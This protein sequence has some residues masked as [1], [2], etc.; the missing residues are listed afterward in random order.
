MA[1][2]IKIIGNIINTTTVSR[3]SS[4]DAALI[5]SRNLQ[6]NF[7]GEGDYIEYFVYDIGGNL[8]NINYSYLDYKLP[9]NQGLTPGVDTLPNTNGSIQTTDVG[10]QSTLATPTSSLY[11]II[12]IDPVADLQNLGYSSGEFQVRYNFFQNKISNYFNQDLFVKEISPNRTEVRLASTTLTNEQI[13]SGSLD[14]IDKLNNSDYYVDYI[15]NFG[16]NEQYIAVNVA[17]D[18]NPN[19]FEILFK[20]YQPLPLSVQEKQTL[21]V[22]EEIVNPYV[23]D[24]NLDKLIT[25]PPPPTLRG[26]N[27]N[28]PVENQGTISTSYSNYSNLISSIQSLQSSSYSKIQNLMSTQSIDINVDYTDFNNFVFFGSAYQRVVN[29]YNKVKQIEDYNNFI[30]TY[31]PYVATTASLQTT[32][33]QYSASIVNV[34]T[35]FDGYEYY[36]YFESSSYAWPK[37]NSNKPFILL[38]TGSVQTW[39]NNLTASAKTYDLNNYDNLEFAVP[40]FI[41]D[42]ENNQPFLLFLNM[43]GQYFDNIWIYLKS[44]TDINLANNNLDYGISKDLVYQQLQSL[45]VKLYNSQAGDSVANYLIGANTG[46]SIWDND[47]TITGSY[48]NNIPRKDLVAELYKRIYHNLPLLLKTKGTVA[49]LNYLMTIFGIPNQTYYVIT[50][51]SITQSYYT[52]TGSNFT[53][54]ILNVKEFGGSLKSELIKGYNN[55]KVRI[56]S[57]TITGSVLSSELSLQTYPTTSATF[58]DDDLHYV[59]ISFSPQTQIDTYISGAIASNNST[60]SLDD[61]IGDPR[62]QYSASYPDLDNQRKLYF[63]TGTPGYPGFTGSLLDYNGFIRLIE[64]FDNSLFKMLNDFVPERTSLSTGVTINSPVLERN[65]TVYSVPNVTNQQIYEANYQTSSITAQYGP[66][67]EDLQGDKKPFFTGELSGSVV[68]VNQYF[69]D[70]YNQYLGDWNVWN[71]QHTISESIDLNKFLHSDWNV[72]L[73]NVSSSVKSQFRNNIEYTGN[74]LPTTSLTYPA[75]LQDS[76]LTLR[77][78]NT[79]RYE[80]SKLTSLT[81]NIYTSGSYTGSNG[82]SIQNG[83]KSYGKTAV[84]DRQS[85]KIGWV[86]NIPSQSLNFFDKTQIQLKY[87]VDSNLNITDL[88]L[89]NNN[90][91]EIQNTFKSGD[92]VVLSLSDTTKPSFQKPL[93]GTKTIFRGGYSYDPILYREQKE[94]LYI[95]LNNT[96][97]TTNYLG[98]KATATDFYSYQNYGAAIGNMAGGPYPI[99]NPPADLGNPRFNNNPLS[100]LSGFGYIFL[101]NYGGRTQA[102]QGSLLTTPMVNEV[103]DPTG[104]SNL[105]STLA[106][107]PQTSFPD[108]SWTGPIAQGYYDHQSGDRRVYVFD[109]SNSNSSTYISFNNSNLNNGFVNGYTLDNFTDRNQYLFKAQTP[110][111]YTISGNIPFFMRLSYVKWFRFR[112]GIFATSNVPDPFHLFGAKFK[113]VAVV[114]KSNNPTSPNSWIY[115]ASTRIQNAYVPGGGFTYNANNNEFKIN[116]GLGGGAWDSDSTDG[117][118]NAGLSSSNNY[119]Y[120]IAFNLKF[121]N[122][123]I[124]SSTPDEINV[125]LAAGEV[126]RLRLYFYDVDAFFTWGRDASFDIGKP[127]TRT[128]LTIPP[129]PSVTGFTSAEIDYLNDA[130]FAIE[131]RSIPIVNYSNIV[132]YNNDNV[133]TGTGN[134]EILFTPTISSYIVSG[135]IFTPSSLIGTNNYYSPIVDNLTIQSQ[136]LIRI[137][138]I[139]DPTPSYYTVKNVEEY[140]ALENGSSFTG[141]VAFASS[142]DFNVSTIPTQY[143]SLGRRSVIWFPNNIV[144]NNGS[145]QNNALSDY[146]NLIYNSTDING[147]KK[148][149]IGNMQNRNGISPSTVFTIKDIITCRVVFFDSSLSKLYPMTF[150]IL[151]DDLTV[152]T[153]QRAFNTDYND[154]VISSNTIAPSLS[155]PYTNTNPTPTFFPQI[156]SELYIKAT[157]DKDVSGTA[158]LPLSQISQNFAILRPKPDE[159]SII[160]EYSKQLGD[161]SQT[162]L[163]PQDANDEIKNNIGKIFQSLNVDLSNQNITQ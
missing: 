107:Q 26:P 114:E 99:S 78:Y 89:K 84:I 122:D 74:F 148:I 79:S 28:I 160:I 69:E 81:Y 110:G 12:E 123:N 161:V 136:D 126:L 39:Y 17:L 152:P 92:N 112:R 62:Q 113:I 25:P 9:P 94:P 4:Q 19:G 3:Y 52:P 97:S 40:N 88:T 142:Y 29:F 43:V 147:A 91:F 37:I 143:R 6:D 44:I 162:I 137:G 53:S 47:F 13:K 105:Y 8:L 76:Y 144:G 60:W 96:I 151:S 71:L 124:S 80:G 11:P 145:S 22:T 111:T 95:R 128:S 146:F 125:T 101:K 100:S 51:G 36:L 104:F 50:S 140:Y 139:N 63:Q 159:T 138:S 27:F 16:N 34:I 116:S 158:L 93:D 35:Q 118:E 38:S 54:S 141:N 59:D 154:W 24:I 117:G 64:Y 87:L 82:I 33:N 127:N 132:E 56:V 156:T 163:I 85:Y 57:N 157:L 149:T 30:T 83:D 115:V 58:R 7:G 49:G 67:Y 45:G 130:V 31:A 102:S 70:N 20:L 129:F 42:D 14:L 10:V 46:S 103:L 121:K 48:L 90:L 86:K 55:N 75:E 15:L 77:S 108:I 109:L 133:F 65:K 131:E 5:S 41:R 18:E 32:I 72:L 98:Y 155:T 23:F 106:N 1:N 134:N 135:S 68:D 119:L 66:L 21:W 153:N 61:F 73:N 120:R 150:V 2:N